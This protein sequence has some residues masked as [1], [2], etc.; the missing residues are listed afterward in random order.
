MIIS[1]IHKGLEK[2]YKSGKTSGVQAKH[3]KRLRLILTNL[4]QA[5]TPEDMDLPGLRLHELKGSRKGIWSVS[6]SGNWR[7]TFRFTGKDAEI[8]NYE[9]YH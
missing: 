3:A 8:V 2:F 1:F 4:D 5:E 7:I 9:D 6:V